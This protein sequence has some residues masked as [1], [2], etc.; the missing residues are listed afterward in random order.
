MTRLEK[1][2]EEVKAAR[3]G[4][5]RPWIFDENGN[6]REDVLVGDVIPLLEE[7]KEYEIDITDE[8]IEEFINDEKTKGNN[9]Y[10]WNANISDDLQIHS[11]EYDDEL[12][13]VI[14]VHLR[15]DIRANY[16]DY[17]AV[18]MRGF[19]EFYELESMLQH[20]HITDTLVADINLMD[21]Y[22]SV[23]DYEHDDEL[24]EFYE[25][26]IKDTL[27]EIMAKQKEL[28][29]EETDN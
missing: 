2:I 12:T 1:V 25:I 20:K 16:S 18:K 15:G 6:I 13:L 19:Y 26:E 29:P 5:M 23:Y 3:T 21:E 8:E 7:L 9:T 10:N 24:G 22:Y 17:F 11:Q 14:A 4:T 28:F 27:P